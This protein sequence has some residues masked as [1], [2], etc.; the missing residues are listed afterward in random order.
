MTKS[1]ITSSL[2]TVSPK[3]E[4]YKLHEGRI[5]LLQSCVWLHFSWVEKINQRLSDLKIP[6]FALKSMS[7]ERFGSWEFLCHINGVTARYC[8]NYLNRPVRSEET[9]Q[10]MNTKKLNVHLSDVGELSWKLNKTACTQLCCGC[11][12]V[13]KAHEVLFHFLIGYCIILLHSW[14]SMQHASHTLGKKKER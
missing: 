6:S 8:Q 9:N 4:H 7:H 1:W 12:L 13:K 10:Y 2:K 3:S 11:H 5:D 14:Y